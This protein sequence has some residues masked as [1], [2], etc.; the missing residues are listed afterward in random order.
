MKEAEARQ[1]FATAR[2]AHLATVRSDGSPHVVP[3]V[4]AVEGNLVLSAVDAKAKTSRSLQRLANIR[5]EPRVSVLVDRYHEDWDRLWWVRA[6]GEASVDHS[7]RTLQRVVQALTAKYPQYHGL[8]PL[9]GPAIR[10][11]V[12]RWRFWSAGSMA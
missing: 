11:R 8:A 6:D 7:A 5:A 1:L 4:F 9:I 2:V 12:T 3:I 10:I